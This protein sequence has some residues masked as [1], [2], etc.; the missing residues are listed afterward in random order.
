MF[1]PLWRPT[2]VRLWV[3]IVTGWLVGCAGSATDPKQIAKRRV[4]RMAAYE[5]LTPEQKAL[6]DRGQIQV[7][8]PSDAVYIAWG[9]P[10]QTLLRGDASG[11]ETTWLYTGSTTDQYINWTYVEVPGPK[12]RTYL[13]RVTTT[14][15][16]FRDYVS[17]RLIFR[18]GLVTSWE[19]LPKPPS[20]TIFTPAAGPVRG[21][22]VF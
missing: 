10:G 19:M 2:A 1:S 14:E 15:Y 5:A 12:G 21:P 13:D 16:A 9:A 7:G 17:A 22:L 20:N 3:L 11:E 4:E 18:E 6:V 8:M